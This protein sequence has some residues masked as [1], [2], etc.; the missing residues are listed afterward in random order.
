M[1]ERPVP[2]STNLLLIIFDASE[3]D[4]SCFPFERCVVTNVR[5]WS[6]LLN[7]DEVRF[8]TLV[9]V[10]IISNAVAD[11]RSRSLS[12]RRALEGKPKPLEKNRQR[13]SLA[14]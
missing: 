4:G 13:S 10:E 3:V 14:L 9:L 7:L 6:L 8:V 5:H 1:R 11:A 2:A 12:A